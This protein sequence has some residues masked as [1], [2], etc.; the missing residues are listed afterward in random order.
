MIW[1]SKEPPGS[2]TN[3]SPVSVS[4]YLILSPSAVPWGCWESKYF[5]RRW[6]QASLGWLRSP[7]FGSCICQPCL[8]LGGEQ[9]AAH[10]SP[11]LLPGH[12]PTQGHEGLVPS[13]PAVNPMEVSCCSSSRRL[14]VASG[15]EDRVINF[16]EVY[17]LFLNSPGGLRAPSGRLSASN[18]PAPRDKTC[19]AQFLGTREE[20]TP[21]QYAL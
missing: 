6:P 19:D 2:N 18:L 20:A 12:V 10:C 21:T 5:G 16:P 3:S 8:P 11:G 1:S 15:V 7:K 4:P 14:D 9:A 13:Q 17:G